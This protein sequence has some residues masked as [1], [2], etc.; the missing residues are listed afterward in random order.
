MADMLTAMGF[1]AGAAA[2]AMSM[3]G[4]DVQRAVDLLTSGAIPAG[5][6]ASGGGA[7]GGG[8]SGGGGASRVLDM[9]QDS[10]SELSDDL[11]LSDDD[12]GPT[13]AEPSKQARWFWA[14]DSG[15]G[16][17]DKW[18]E[19]DKAVSAPQWVARL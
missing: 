15:Q 2:T 16:Q 1:D 18:I 10:E 11:P 3:S 17:Q 9:S 14:G 8:A 13:S 12:A 5:G 4:N 7:S 19:Y 6:G